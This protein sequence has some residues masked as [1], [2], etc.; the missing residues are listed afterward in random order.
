MSKWIPITD[1]SIEKYKEDRECV[2]LRVEHNGE[3][4]ACAGVWCSTSFFGHPS[5]W[6]V[7]GAILDDVTDY[8]THFQP[9]PSTDLDKTTTSE[10]Q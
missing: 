7:P 9:F 5:R 10:E 4:F 3:V 8:V 1:P 2:I 6:V